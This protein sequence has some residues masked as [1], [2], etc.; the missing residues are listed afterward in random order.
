MTQFKVYCN[1]TAPEGSQTLLAELQREL[2]FVPNVYGVIAGSPAALEGV[3]T[4]NTSFGA[5]GFSGAEREIISLATSV[6]NACPYCIAGHSSFALKQGVS[7]DVIDAVRDDRPAL[8]PKLEALR[9]TTSNVVLQR[10]DIA[11]AQLAHF[12]DAGFS[13][14]AFLELLLGVAAK[15]MTNFASKVAGVPVDAQFVAEAR[16]P[17]FEHVL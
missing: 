8:D 7:Q 14:K 1:E 6:A 9:S 3:M 15:T 16:P 2:G 5:S 11:P 4:L 13:K 10:G 17:K 12:Y